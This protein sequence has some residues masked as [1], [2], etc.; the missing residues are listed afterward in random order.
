[1]KG[2]AFQT[3]GRRTGARGHMQD[4]R[5]CLISGDWGS[6]AA[7]WGQYVDI[8]ARRQH[9]GPMRSLTSARDKVLLWLSPASRKNLKKKLPS[10]S[11]TRDSKSSF[12]FDFVWTY[13][14]G[15]P[16]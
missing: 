4:P 13:R 12:R 3:T 14:F 16:I 1:M 2:G 8:G 5:G 6:S 7:T 11:L 10:S 15:F 9:S